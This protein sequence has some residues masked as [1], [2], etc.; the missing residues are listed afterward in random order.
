M[1]SLFMPAPAGV[2][3]NV[4]FHAPVYLGDVASTSALSGA[5]S[6][7]V[8]GGPSSGG[9][10]AL[11]AL[12]VRG[13]FSVSTDGGRSFVHLP[14]S[15]ASLPAGGALLDGHDFGTL[16]CEG[17]ACR[18]ASVTRWSANITGGGG[19]GA[20]A[21]AGTGAGAGAGAGAAPTITAERVGANVTFG[22]LPRAAAALR[23][24]GGGTVR[25]GQ[26]W[27]KTAAVR[28][29][30]EAG[31][32]AESTIALASADGFAW[33]YLSTLPW[34]VAPTP[35]PTPA[36]PGVCAGC[37]F[38]CGRGGDDCTQCA[39]C[40]ASARC[41]SEALCMGTCNGGGGAHWCGGIVASSAAP[42]QAAAAA[43]VAG[44]RAAV[45]APNSSLALLNFGQVLALAASPA[46]APGGA[47]TYATSIDG[48]YTWSDAQHVAG[49]GGVR[50]RLLVL[51]DGYAP[52]LLSGGAF[53][54]GN[55]GGSSS[56]SSSSSSSSSSRSSS[57]SDNLS[58]WVDW[59]GDQGYPAP[60]PKVTPYS[61]SY[62]HNAMAQ[63]P[64]PQFPASANDTSSAGWRAGGLTT[65]LQSGGG[66]DG[67]AA[68]S[69]VVFYGVPGGSGSSVAAMALRIELHLDAGGE[70]GVHC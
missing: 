18:A 54:S 8:P 47:Y 1:R 32:A 58:L 12:S 20:G 70:T 53:S 27:L 46:D 62:L 26:R 59:L 15:A 67:G 43:G 17:P 3:G 68:C 2:Q 14:S 22:G 9:G 6:L 52:L 50:P 39:S 56:N 40:D 19:G 34:H 21:G 44:G 10:A 13:G 51:G 16:V 5:A 61:L 66:S 49:A 35:A 28:Y 69:A 37:G 25:D 41:H 11:L 64:L 55:G 33:R 57:S 65:L 38:S 29:A 63:A 30:A 60:A 48:G 7:D 31:T 4:T 42:G 23:L 24:A 36:P 45:Q